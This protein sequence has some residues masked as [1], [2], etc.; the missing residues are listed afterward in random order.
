MEQEPQ[1]CFHGITEIYMESDEEEQVLEQEEDR[2]KF[3]DK[4]EYLN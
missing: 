3:Q 1:T 2:E 4:I